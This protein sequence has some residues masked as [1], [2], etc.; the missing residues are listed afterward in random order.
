MIS[1]LLG[2]GF[3]LGLKHA[4]DADHVM[5]VATLAG[6]QR[7]LARSSLV[8]LFW[9]FGHTFSLLIAGIVLLALGFNVPAKV[10]LLLELGVAIM[11]MGMGINVLL[12]LLTGAT[13]HLHVHR[14]GDRVHAHPHIHGEEVLHNG[15]AGHDDHGNWKNLT[16]AAR[17]GKGSF[18]VGT[19]HGLAGSAGLMLVIV[20]TI[21]DFWEGVLY[22]LSFGAGSTGGMLVM[23]TA[24]GI[25]SVLLSG[26]FQKTYLVLRAVAGTGSLLFGVVLGW[27]I[28]E[29][30]S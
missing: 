29:V 14:H 23:S 17:K 8:G 22:I 4:L 26:R 10:A 3:V 19:V 25:P 7:S 28:L 13:L 15:V 11:L 16:E 1:Y 18:L 6:E 2:L 9:G 27:Q 21:P 24:L 20:A 30:L 5:A 12:K